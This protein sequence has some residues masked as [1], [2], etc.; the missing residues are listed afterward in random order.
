MTAASF[1]VGYG[2]GE[3]EPN[4]AP[5][6]SAV[7]AAG[8]V[9]FSSCEGHLEGDGSGIPRRPTV[10]FYADEAAAKRVHL[11]LHEYRSRFRC[12]WGLTANFVAHLQTDEWALGWAIE[13][14]GIIEDGPAETFEQ[15]TLAA[16]RGQDLP[17]HIELFNTLLTR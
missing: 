11:A 9:T 5:L 8:Y 3:V 14:W 7:Q 4:I 6:V 12:S 16:V 17:M 2:K 15:R 1:V 13:N 10:C